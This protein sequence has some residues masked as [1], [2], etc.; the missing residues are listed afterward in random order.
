M[1]WMISVATVASLVTFVGIVVWAWS[2]AR[3]DANRESAML[4]FELPDESVAATHRKEAQ[5]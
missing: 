4:P 3:A 1:A 5:S 2:G